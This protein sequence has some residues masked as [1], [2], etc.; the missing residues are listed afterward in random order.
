MNIDFVEGERQWVNAE[1]LCPEISQMTMTF[2]MDSWEVSVCRSHR[3]SA[4][5]CGLSFD[6]C[7]YKLNRRYY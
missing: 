5:V 1:V 7:T 2:A 6:S 3:A 4:C